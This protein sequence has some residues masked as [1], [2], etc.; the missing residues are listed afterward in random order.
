M[1]LMLVVSFLGAMFADFHVDECTSSD[2]EDIIYPSICN[3]NH[4]DSS[5]H[6]HIDFHFTEH[7]C[8][9]CPTLFLSYSSIYLRNFQ[10]STF[11]IENNN[12]LQFLLAYGI[13]HPPR[14]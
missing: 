5:D 8:K 9:G 1:S 13:E 4:N 6:I 11:T 10:E 7:C 3:T 12:I 14:I 2:T